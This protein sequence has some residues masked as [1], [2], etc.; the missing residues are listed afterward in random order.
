MKI[1]YLAIVYTLL[2]LLS[3]LFLWNRIGKE[4]GSSIDMLELNTKVGK[5]SEEILA[6]DMT[7]EE[8]FQSEVG[9]IEEE[10]DCRITFLSDKNY[11]SAFSALFRRRSMAS[12]C[13]V[14]ACR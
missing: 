7:A 5:I 3:G 14:L 6:L 2:L 4:T 9:K 11:E 12:A 8:S 1:R 10:Y 13:F